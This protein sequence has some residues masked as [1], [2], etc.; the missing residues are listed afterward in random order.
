M[1]NV[2]VAEL[3][4]KACISDTSEL[5]HRT[6]I[7]FYHAYHAYKTHALPYDELRPLS[8]N[9][10]NT[11]GNLTV[12]LIDTLDTLMLLRDYHEFT[13]AV[14]YLREH[15][16]FDKNS[17]VSLFETNIR[18]LGG[19]L[20]AH[21]MLSGA[22]E[23]NDM[24]FD[25]W[26][27]YPD[28]DGFLLYSAWDL[29]ERLYPAFDTPTGIPFGAI[30]LQHGVAASESRV[31]S[32]AGA[33][34]LLLE[35]GTL[36]VLT[37]IPKYYRA[38]YKAMHALFEH[39]SD[40]GLVGN[41]V[42]IDSGMWVAT[43]SGVG[44]S[45]DS[46]Y[47]YMLKGYIAFGDTR[48]LHMYKKCYSAIQR[49]VRRGVWYL[50]AD[51]Y[52]GQTRSLYQ[53][54]LSAF[55]PGL[56]TLTGT[57]DDAAST[58][59][60]HFGVWK[61]FGAL[62]E[63]FHVGA[64]AVVEGMANYPLRPELVES[65]FYLEWQSGDCVWRHVAD[66]VLDSL[67]TG[68]KVECG[69]GGMSDVRSGR[70]TDI[71]DSF[72]MSETLKYVYL[73]VADDDEDEL[74]W[75]RTGKYVFTTEAHPLHIQS[76]VPRTFFSETPRKL[77]RVPRCMRRSKIGRRLPGG[78]SLAGGDAPQFQERWVNENKVADDVRAQVEAVVKLHGM[79]GVKIGG[80]FGGAAGAFKVVKV[81]DGE[82]VFEAV[83]VAK[84][85]CARVW[86]VEVVRRICRWWDIGRRL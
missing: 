4:P 25:A 43:D 58:T 9:G 41:H 75:A 46:Y 69:F 51:M 79:E 45:I 37:R 53:S 1:L 35:F 40:I 8:C 18:V 84:G 66:A 31:A 12:S 59:R 68:M 86:G 39:A 11:F 10:T 77:R 17:T 38:A 36:S 74:H 63:G 73:I 78:W 60:A 33:G 61:R 2:I 32:T 14:K 55:F 49:Y 54:S 6:R 70:L 56:Q 7:N 67:E 13:W 28:Y 80:V 57:Y 21:N 30:H 83:D 48:L 15:M 72:V 42:N 23:Q 29:A 34:S 44:G 20:S 71:M 81:R 50:D 65:V 62:P 82:V 85:G 3:S 47:E 27:W 26:L 76:S 24:R 22:E 19:L 64:D 52:S 5:L 16:T